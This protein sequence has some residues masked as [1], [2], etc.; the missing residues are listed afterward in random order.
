VQQVKKHMIKCN[1]IA[2]NKA[3]AFTLIELLVVIAI[4]AILAA[5][6]FPVFAQAKMAAKKT[7]SLSNLKNIG[8][9]AQ[10]YLADNDDVFVLWSN[11]MNGLTPAGLAGG[12]AFNFQNMYNWLLNP[13]IKNGLKSTSATAGDIDGIWANPVSKPYF[14][15]FSN[16]Y[17][18]NHWSLGGFSSCARST[19]IGVPN[20]TLPAICSGRSAATYLEFADA[21]YNFP[22]N[23]TSL[24]SSAE[25]IVFTDGAQISRPPSYALAFPSGGM[26]SIAVW[27]PY[28]PGKGGTFSRITSTVSN[29][30]R[31]MLSGR[32]TAV[33]YADSHVKIVDT[34]TLY[35]EAYTAEGG[36]WRGGVQN[37]LR[38]NKGWAR[39][40]PE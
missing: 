8:T 1:R 36:A 19:A 20:N 13:Y 35:H 21:A 32:K 6:L 5:I 39:S 4:I 15:S 14:S 11:N 40:W 30:I 9:G 31:L 2:P 22:A 16:T 18:Y 33:S 37:N 24:Q 12:S 10:L 27:G 38:M 17:A 34:R 25:T 7:Q 23:A 28:E 3:R 26:E 29:N